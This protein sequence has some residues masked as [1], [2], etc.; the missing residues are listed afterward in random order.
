[1]PLDTGAVTQMTP[2][3]VGTEMGSLSDAGAPARNEPSTI[4]AAL[5][6]T[7]EF[8]GLTLQDLADATRIRRSYLAA[9]EDMKLDVLPSRPFTIGYVRAYAQALGMDGDAAVAR[10]KHD[11]PERVEPLRAPVGVS[12][13]RDPRLTLAAGAAAVVLSAVLVW[14]LAQHA[15]AEDKAP[16]PAI[17]EASV[18]WSGAAASKGPVVLSAAQPAPQ[19]SDAPAPY[20]T[21]GLA[22]AA[23]TGPES[24]PSVLAAMEPAAAALAPVPARINPR[25][26]VYGSPA[27][28]SVVTFHARKTASLIVRGPDGAVYFARQLAAGESYRAP[29]LKGLSVDVSDPSAFDVYANGALQGPLVANQTQIGKLTG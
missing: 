11:A 8:R 12:R 18:S 2:M 1:M 23:A 14:N 24:A 3:S 7:R 17:P 15:M 20:V 19:E 22:A 10:F 27:G 25:A 29:Q 26:A 9:L 5:R 13:E 4:G 28:Q 21:P 16:S 6:A